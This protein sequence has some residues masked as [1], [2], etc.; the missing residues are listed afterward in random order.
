MH[1]SVSF[2]DEC[3]ATLKPFHAQLAWRRGTKFQEVHPGFFFLF[4]VFKCLSV[5][6]NYFF[7][8]YH[9]ECFQF[10]TNLFDELFREYFFSATRN[11]LFI[12]FYFFGHYFTDCEALSSVMRKPISR[13][14]AYIL[15]LSYFFLFS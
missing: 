15:F 9:A 10:E 4:K 11:Y 13:R 3:E 2:I 1:S 12:F 8:Y 5:L 7:L 6:Y 14:D